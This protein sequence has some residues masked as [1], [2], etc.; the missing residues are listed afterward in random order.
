VLVGD[1]YP[2]PLV[3]IN[4]RDLHACDIIR[5]VGE[6]TS[7][8]EK[9]WFSPFFGLPFCIHCDGFGQQFLL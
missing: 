9:D 3:M 4:F 1:V 2:R 6:I 8:H 7:Y 5:I